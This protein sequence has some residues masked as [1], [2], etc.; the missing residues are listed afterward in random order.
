MVRM[1]E[2]VNIPKDAVLPSAEKPQE[3]A[4]S[5]RGGASEP[6][7]TSEPRH[8]S[9]PRRAS[10]AR[11]PPEEGLRPER[12]AQ[13]DGLPKRERVKVLAIMVSGTTAACISQSMMIA[14]LP[15]I[16]HEYAVD[17]SLGQL[18]TTGYIFTLGLISA[19]TAYLMNRVNSK[20]LFL[21]AMGC[22]VIGCAAALVAPNY[23]LLLAARLLQA[24]GAGIA[25][26]LI[27]L[28]ALNVYP[29]SQYGRAMSIVG[30][31]IGFAP[32]IGPTISGFLIDLWGWR[33]VFVV[34]GAITLV[35]MAA[36]ALFLD[37]VVRRPEAHEHFDPA[38]ALL[39]TTGF[40]AVMAG[41]TALMSKDA[42][43]LAALVPCAAGFIALV[44]FVRRELRVPNPLLKLSCFRD[45]TFTVSTLMVVLSHIMFMA[46][47]IMVPLFVQDIQG[48]SATVSGLTILPGAI[49]TGVMNPVTGRYL[50]RHGPFPL[51]AMGGLLVFAGTVAFAVIDASVPEWIVT[52]IYGVRATGIAC[53]MMPMTAHACSTLAEEDLAQAT[54]IITSAR[55]LIGSL[56]SSVLI[57]VMAL[58]AAND[59]GVDL[60]G[61][62]VSFWAQAAVCAVGI[63]IGMALLPRKHGKASRK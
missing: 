31:I 47:S 39:Y 50:D 58:A 7:H 30:L 14:A 15:T 37:D 59:L 11:R 13:R 29:K 6:R 12:S 25:L 48:Q 61:F 36:T 34:L 19:M 4:P 1:T 26:P 22:F 35:V 57:A 49:M 24:G 54:A 38:S 55:Q 42:S 18:L 60:F 46:P 52:V 53:I 10:S 40:V 20:K 8:A 2:G 9:E 21:T 28:V 56:S 43:N 17:A 45:R 5:S 44:V 62:H 27:Q 33:S 41:T 23:L 32:A 16:M 3:G 51:L 63:G